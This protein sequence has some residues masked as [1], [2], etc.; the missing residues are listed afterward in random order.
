VAVPILLVW[1]NAHGSV[2]L[3]AFLTMILGGIEIVRERRPTLRSV[4]LVVVP[5]LLVLAT[6]YGPL[7]T[8]RYYHLL[9]IDPPFGDNVTEWR[10]SDPAWDT[11]TF[12]LLAALALVLAVRG[13]RRLHVFDLLALGLTLVGAV[14]AI[15]GIVWFAMTCCVL[16]PVAIG[17]ALG[18]TSAPGK[19]AVNRGIAALTALVVIAGVVFAFVR[20]GDAYLRKWPEGAVTAVRDEAARPGVQV[21]ATSRHADWLLWRLPELRGRM[22]W[23]V[24]FEIYSPEDFERIV[25]FRGEQGPAWKAVADGYEVVVLETD[26][27]PSHIADFLSEPGARTIYADDRVTVITRSSGS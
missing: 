25:R 11:L 13:R 10:W 24:R 18:R 14:T 5:P 19:P 2:A 23:D 4:L 1:A 17:P 22:A 6:P 21:L 15:R 27:D 8:A 3:G 12:Y 20:P 16:L 7:E 9:L 26:E